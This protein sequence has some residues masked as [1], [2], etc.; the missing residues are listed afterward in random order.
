MEAVF[1]V[2]QQDEGPVAVLRGDWTSTGLR[3][4]ERDLRQEADR[5]PGLVVDVRK[6][7]R[8]DTA[9]AYAILEAARDRLPQ[10]RI[11]AR[12][13]TLRLLQLVERALEQELP[14]QP[15]ENPMVE[16]L[17]RI[18]RGVIG[19]GADFW[20][21]MAFNGHLAVAF[22]RAVVNPTRIRWAPLFSL[23][24]RA[25][26]DAIP[27]VAVT[28]FFIGSVIA[29]IG[30]NMLS[31]FGA[32]VFTVELIGVAVLREFGIVITAVLLAGR[33]A[34]S[35]AAE[36]GAMK[37][38]QEIDAMRV[39]GVDP[40]EALVLPRFLALLIT[41]PILTFIAV[42]AGLIGGILVCWGV[43]HLSPI[44]FL[45]RVAENVGV[46]HFWVGMSKAPVM[47]A[48]VAAIG[49]RQGMEV[50]GDV[51]SLGRRVTAAV[52]HA[53]F[54][55]ILLDAIFAMVYSELDV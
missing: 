2:E 40:F 8:C 30:A 53:I 1:T 31:D 4:A 9:G 24:E 49:C 28:S 41:I 52:V 7:R 26:L 3:G 39:M 54:S 38:N 27:I 13:E 19:V 11:V 34:S 50:G 15:A 35:F 21:T 16:M 33:S 22:G 10:D 48:V 25:G 6:V 45:K 55:I 17:R 44:F 47:A 23:A 37:M 32:Q 36:I 29:F 12:P 20:D 42:A 5:N 51:D 46:R 14:P 43:L 18:G